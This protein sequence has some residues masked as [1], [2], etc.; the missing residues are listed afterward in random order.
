MEPRAATPARRLEAIRA[1]ARAGV[2]V[3]VLASPMIPGLNDHELEAILAAAAEAG[4]TGASTLMVRLPLE[5][6]DLFT[7][8][9]QTHAPDRAGRVLTLIR[10]VRGGALY[11]SRFGS[12]FTGEG[13]LARLLADRFAKACRRYGFSRRPPLDVGQFR[14]PPRAGDQLSLL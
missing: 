5:L 11:D 7:E 9:L 13:P 8:W 12:R 2:P 4:A 1:L 6:R 14:P 3:T 10:D